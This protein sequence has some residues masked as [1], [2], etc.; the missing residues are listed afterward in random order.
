MSEFDWASRMRLRTWDQ[1]FLWVSLFAVVVVS[2][3]YLFA[4]ASEMGEVTDMESSP[5]GGMTG[6]HQ[7]DIRDFA[8]M[9]IMWSIMMVAMMIPTALRAISVYA[10]VARMAEGRATPLA[11]TYSFVVGY[12]LIWT[13]F[14]AGATMLQGV[15]NMLGLL[16]PSMTTSS[17]YLGAA[18]LIS[19]GVYQLTPLKDLCLEHCQSPAT[20]LA[21]RFGPRMVDGIGLGVRH[22]IY[23]LGCCWLLMALLF[24]GGVMNLIWIAMISGFV[25]LEKLLPRAFHLSQISSAAMIFSGIG[26]IAMA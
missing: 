25:L 18:L 26:Y 21:G 14:S 17:S 19:A 5:A 23:C 15:L 22:G 2:W 11:S 12:L 4:V 20:F 24:V 7:W 16:S 1:L 3:L 13:L 8:L 10:G 9:F 6:M